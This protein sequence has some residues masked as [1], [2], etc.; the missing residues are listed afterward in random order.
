SRF[1]VYWLHNFHDWFFSSW[2]AA[3]M[4]LTIF[5]RSALW[6]LQARANRQF[7]RMG[8]LAPKMKELQAKFQ[9]NPQKYQQETMK[10]YR[11]YGVNPLGGCVPMLIQLP[12][13][14]GFYSA[15]QV[16][17]ELRGQTFLWIRDLSMPD[18]VGHLAG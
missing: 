7:K 9:D 2:G 14:I 11:E 8:L 3:I 12:I 17:A 5:V 16:A 18:T 15:L 6:P 13:F 4:L 10:L 1:M